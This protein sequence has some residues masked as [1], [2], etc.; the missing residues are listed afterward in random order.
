MKFGFQLVNKYGA[1]F[2][3][4]T[5]FMLYRQ[6]QAF[7]VALALLVEFPDHTIFDQAADLGHILNRYDNV[8]F[9]KMSRFN[10]SWCLLE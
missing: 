4:C 1:R 8:L 7:Y 2:Y 3:S 10:I 9:W 6:L 5:H